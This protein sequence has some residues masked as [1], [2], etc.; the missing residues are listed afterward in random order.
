M[1]QKKELSSRSSV[2]LL[3]PG[4]SPWCSTCT[5]ACC[6]C[7]TGASGDGGGGLA[8]KVEDA[9]GGIRGSLGSK[10]VLTFVFHVV[11]LLCLLLFKL[12]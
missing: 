5:L 12:F 3:G 8:D 9:A 2:C 11:Y 1:A 6:P 10:D 4:R 7:D